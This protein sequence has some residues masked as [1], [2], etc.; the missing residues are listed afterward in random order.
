VSQPCYLL[1]SRTTHCTAQPAVYFDNNAT[2]APCKRLVELSYST[3]FRLSFASAQRDFKYMRQD[4]RVDVRDP[5]TGDPV[6]INLSSDKSAFG[7]VKNPSSPLGA[8]CTPR[9]RFCAS[10]RAQSLGDSAR[11]EGLLCSLHDAGG[12]ATPCKGAAL[13]MAESKRRWHDLERA[14]LWREPTS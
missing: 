9:A 10:G 14:D 3:S 5:M 2:T 1:T 11:V 4:T 13:H 6:G 8:S 7:V 12:S